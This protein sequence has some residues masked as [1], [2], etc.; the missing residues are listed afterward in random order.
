MYLQRECASCV[1]SSDSGRRP[2]EGASWSLVHSHLGRV[3]GERGKGEEGGRRE[4]GRREEGGR[5]EEGEREKRSK[6][7]LHE[8]LLVGRFSPR[9]LGLTTVPTTTH[10]L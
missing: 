3:E 2:G 9:W 1:W 4:G 7:F 8:H 10:E 5:E 6:V